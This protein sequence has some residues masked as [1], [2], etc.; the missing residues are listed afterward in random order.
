MSQ[1]V[2]DRWALEALRVSF[3]FNAVGDHMTVA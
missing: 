1:E 2:D 3:G